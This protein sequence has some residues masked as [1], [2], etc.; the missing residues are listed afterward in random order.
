MDSNFLNC[1]YKN[2]SVDNSQYVPNIVKK[3]E[4]EV[5]KEYAI[6]LILLTILVTSV[7]DKDKD[8]VKY[9]IIVNDEHTEY[10]NFS[11]L[12]S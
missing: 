8:K 6:E 11:T 12:V 5:N 1:I 9:E 10:K 4:Y 7:N 2:I 3:E